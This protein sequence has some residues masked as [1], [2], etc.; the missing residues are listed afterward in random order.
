MVGFVG[1]ECCCEG[2]EGPRRMEGGQD[3]AEDSTCFVSHDGWGQFDWLIASI[4]IRCD[5]SSEN[6][7]MYMQATAMYSS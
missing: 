7:R 5:T 1:F 6:V 4:I 3:E 2:R